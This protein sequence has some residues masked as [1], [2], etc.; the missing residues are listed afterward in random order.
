MGEGATQ[1]AN[2]VNLLL[3]R[4]GES[5]GNR[6]RRFG[7][8]GPT[9][10]TDLGHRQAA[11]TAAALARSDEPTVVISSDLARAKQ[12][13]TPIAAAC[14]VDLAFDPGVRERSV[15]L[16]DNMLFT[17]AKRE[18]PSHWDRLV[19]R[20][21]D[22]CPPGG[23]TIDTVYQRVSG[24]V[25]RIVTAHPGKRVI[26]VS[27]GIAIF[28]AIAH[29]FGLGSPS[30]GLRVFALVDNCSVSRFRY[31]DSHWRVEAINDRAHLSDMADEP[32]ADEPR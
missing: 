23:E 17:D 18:H 22:A 7:G 28:H 19:S 20:D 4:H 2:A 27:H 31:R 11:L 29:I 24:S 12:T 21:P 15:G 10:L 6:E 14:G 13:A 16:F 9:P 3:V 1:A 8:H 32:P 25:Q 5:R 30:A 26:V